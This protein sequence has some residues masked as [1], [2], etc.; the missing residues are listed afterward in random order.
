MLKIFLAFKLNS[1]IFSN[2][3][4]SSLVNMF[5]YLLNEYKIPQCT[6]QVVMTTFKTVV[7]LILNGV[8]CK[9]K[10]YNKLKAHILKFIIIRNVILFSISRRNNQ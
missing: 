6:I 5:L 8:K 7:Y 4:T 3:N 1:K 10:T 9:L 2:E